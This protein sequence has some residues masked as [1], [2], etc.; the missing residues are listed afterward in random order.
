VTK[1][2]WFPEAFGT[3]TLEAES[4]IM[5][6]AEERRASFLSVENII[7]NISLEKVN[8]HTASK[9]ELITLPG[10]APDLAERIIAY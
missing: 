10:I 1:P 5:Q 2:T 9:S 6:I 3:S 8:L 7:S 4:P